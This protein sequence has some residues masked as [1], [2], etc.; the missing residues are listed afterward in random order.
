MLNVGQGGVR[1]VTLLADDLIALGT[2]GHEAAMAP[3][4][5]V[6]RRFAGDGAGTWSALQ[7]AGTDGVGFEAVAAAVA[8]D[9]GL[10][11]VGREFDPLGGFARLYMPDRDDRPV[12]EAH[13]DALGGKPA[14]LV[15]AR[16]DTLVLA[17]ATGDGVARRLWVGGFA[18][19]LAPLW[20]IEEPVGVAR[21]ARDVVEDGAGG[22]IVLGVRDAEPGGE[23]GWLRRYVAQPP[24]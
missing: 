13:A 6:V 12:L 7:E 8:P 17:G 5:S 9:G 18:G 11:V 19:D 4:R 23:P 22:L 24:R 21:E 10:W 15:I 16:D 20:A 14:A 1:G 2:D 3:W